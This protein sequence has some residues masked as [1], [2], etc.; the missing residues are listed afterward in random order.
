MPCKVCKT[1]LSE[2]LRT[3]RI[4]PIRTVHGVKRYEW[5]QGY[6]YKLH[7]HVNRLTNTQTTIQKEQLS[8]LYPRRKLIEEFVACQEMFQ[9][10]FDRQQLKPEDVHRWKLAVARLRQFYGF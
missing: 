3:H 4:D 8:E 1:H 2:Y 10:A 5:I 9:I 6:L 7:E